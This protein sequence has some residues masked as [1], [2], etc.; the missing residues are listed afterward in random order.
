MAATQNV[1][2]WG[3]DWLT[4]TGTTKSSR[5]SLESFGLRLMKEEHRCGNELRPWTFKGYE[6]FRSGS[7]EIGTRPDSTIVR[8]SGGLAREHYVEAYH[9]STN[10]SRVD[11]QATVN[12]GIEPQAWIHR[13]FKRAYRWSKDFKKK[14]EVRMLWSNQGTGTLYLNK[15]IS[16]QFGRLYDKGEESLVPMLDGAWRAEVEYKGDQSFH[17]LKSLVSSDDH[18]LYLYQSLHRFFRL[19][20]C[21]LQLTRASTQTIVS[22]RRKT[23]QTRRLEWI[24]KCVRPTVQVLIESGKSVEVLKALGISEATLSGRNK[25]KRVV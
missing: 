12:N 21:E 4:V 16:D 18:Q 14:P 10:C 11:F 7:V 20:T 5:V 2:D 9:A 19:R 8:I 22:P 1:V 6:G 23:D 25:L 13:Q 24:E 3:V 17:Q 15:R